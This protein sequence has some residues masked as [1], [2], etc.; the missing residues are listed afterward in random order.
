MQGV[1]DAFIGWGS[2]ERADRSPTS[3]VEW[4]DFVRQFGGSC[5][6]LSGYQWRIFPEWVRSVHRAVGDEEILPR[7]KNA[8]SA[9][10]NVAP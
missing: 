6:Q 1:D 10:L 3:G 2:A 5:E 4:A 9:A 8:A 7:H